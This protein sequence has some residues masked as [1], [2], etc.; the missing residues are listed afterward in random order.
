MEIYFIVFFE[1]VSLGILLTN[2]D[3]CKE[4]QLKLIQ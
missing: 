3:I 2:I 1:G 4:I